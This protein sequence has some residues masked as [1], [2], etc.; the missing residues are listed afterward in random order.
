MS[1]SYFF[2][3]KKGK[4]YEQGING[5]KILILGASFYCDKVNCQY[6]DK[7]TNEQLKDSS[8]FDSCCPEY[9]RENNPKKLLRHAPSYEIEAFIEDQSSITYAAFTLFLEGFLAKQNLLHIGDS[10]SIWDYVCFTNYV[11]FFLP[12]KETYNRDIDKEKFNES[13]L[14]VISD[15]D[16]DIVICWGNV[17]N[18]PLRDKCADKEDLYQSDYY[19]FR[20]KVH[21]KTVSFV[22]CDH[23][24]SH[25]FILS[26]KKFERYLNEAIRE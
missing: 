13:L 7:C 22:N 8:E 25:E 15:Y 26:Y 21:G 14:G 9:T 2:T 10:E 16:P 23:P 18:T 12:H 5:K 17:I 1:R 20:W 19:R 4:H 3:P 6:Y 24:S 11:Q